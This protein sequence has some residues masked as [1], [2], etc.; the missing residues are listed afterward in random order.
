MPLDDTDNAY[1]RQAEE[2][3]WEQTYGG[4]C[5]ECGGMRLA[6]FYGGRDH[7][8][9]PEE[10]PDFDLKRGKLRSLSRRSRYYG[11]D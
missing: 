10:S 1:R 3:E 4:P 7:E 5:A 2:D 8:W 11:R 9:V 6:H